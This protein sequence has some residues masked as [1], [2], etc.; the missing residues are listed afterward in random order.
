WEAGEQD[1]HAG[2]VAVVLAGLV[3]AA[4]VDVVDVGGV[5][6][7]TLDGGRDGD[8]GQVVGAHAG[9]RPAVAADRR[10]HRRDDDRPAHPPSSSCTRWA[11][12]NAELAAGTP[13]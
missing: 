11:T 5:D 7:D 3:G 13:Q 2:D 4:Q 10:A 9:E 6:A 1:G 12:A 8:R